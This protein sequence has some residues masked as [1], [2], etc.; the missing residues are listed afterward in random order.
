MGVFKELSASDADK[1]IRTGPRR[2]YVREAFAPKVGI[3][4]VLGFQR[5]PFLNVAAHSPPG[6]AFEARKSKDGK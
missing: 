6:A 2:A 5:G 1:Q 4:Q 3:Q